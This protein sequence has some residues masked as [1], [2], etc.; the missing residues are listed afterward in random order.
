M[1][2]IRRKARE[3]RTFDLVE[4]RQEGKTQVG[5]PDSYSDSH[6]QVEEDMPVVEDWQADTPLVEVRIQEGHTEVGWRIVGS[7][8]LVVVGMKLVADLADL[9][10][11]AASDLEVSAA[12]AAE[13]VVGKVESYRLDMEML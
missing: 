10:V 8:T 5:H 2:V 1:R 9:V 3:R 7:N 12:F 13:T 11:A 6:N 4:E